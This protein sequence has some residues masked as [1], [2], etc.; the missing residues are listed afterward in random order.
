[1]LPRVFLFE[2]PVE[3]F[4]VAVLLGCA[5]PRRRGRF[6]KSTCRLQQEYNSLRIGI[7]YSQRTRSQIGGCGINEG[8]NY[9]EKYAE[10]GTKEGSG[11]KV[12][13]T[14]GRFFALYKNR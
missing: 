2:S 8:W 13:I 9:T 10:S 4:H 7:S 3:R 11:S 1:M 14:L 5:L 6:S 12:W